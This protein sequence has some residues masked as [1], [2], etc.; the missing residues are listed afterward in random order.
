MKSTLFPLILC[1]LLLSGTPAFPAPSAGAAQKISLSPA[2][3]VNE[4]GFG[5]AG[6]LV[7][8][9][10]LAGDPK[11]GHGGTPKTVWFPEWAAWHYPAR[12]FL[13][14]GR[15]YRLSD[16]YLYDGAGSGKVTISAGR[17]FRW[18]PLLT[19]ELSHYNVW[20]AHPVSVTT[21]YLEVTLADA[22]TKVPELVL[23]GTLAGPPDAVPVPIPRPLPTMDQLI[24]V[25]AFIDDP[26][27]KMTVGGFVREY[28]NWDWD[29]GDGKTYPGYP[30]NQNKWNPS[31]G[32]G[33]AWDF[34]AY[35]ARLKAAG[36]TV[37]PAL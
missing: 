20:N 1:S 27:D 3:V 18:T 31:Y 5:E 37:C 32:A 13:D 33:G 25:N 16:V 2:L 30:N 24:G 8:E 4:T 12:A 22:G 21:R 34:D 17:P 7:D 36:V 28:H 29:E 11:G 26:A 9:Q 23:Y 6:C 14:L 35:Y 10:A 15:A 19:D